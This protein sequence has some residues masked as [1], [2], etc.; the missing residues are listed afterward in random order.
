MHLQLPLLRRLQVGK[1]GQL[2]ELVHLV[3]GRREGQRLPI[4]RKQPEI[5]FKGFCNSCK[6]TLNGRESKGTARRG[7]QQQQRTQQRQV[8]PFLDQPP[9]GQGLLQ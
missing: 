3:K 8:A 2:R 1:Q 7:K 5:G 9:R 4:R 6:Q